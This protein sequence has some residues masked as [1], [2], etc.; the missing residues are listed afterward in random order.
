[1][2]DFTLNGPG[3]TNN[4]WTPS[5]I[6]V[7]IS[8]IKSDATGWRASSAGTFACFAHNVNYGNTIVVTITIASGGTSNGDDVVYGGII[9]SGGNA[10]GGLVAVVSAFSVKIATMDTAGNETGI[11]AA[12]S[13]TRA[14]ADVWSMQITLSAGTWTF[15]NVTQNGGS[16]FNFGSNTTTTFASETTMAAGGGFEPFN[17]NSFYLSQF[18]GTGVSGGGLNIVP[19]IGSL[20]ATGVAPTVTPAINT[21]LTPFVARHGS[22]M[23]IPDKRILVPQRKIFLP[24]YRKAA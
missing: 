1:M 11:G 15:S 5:N 13:C 2:A 6:I 22:G 19:T 16:A 14:N 23:L 12:Q 17:N 20:T 21:V 9:R 3:T 10:G 7:P 8:T 18:T 4:P 24:T